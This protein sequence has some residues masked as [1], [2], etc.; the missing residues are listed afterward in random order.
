VVTDIPVCQSGFADKNIDSTETLGGAWMSAIRVIAL[1]PIFLIAGCSTGLHE[2]V[3]NGFK[4]GP[5]YCRPAAPVAEN[6]IDYQDSRVISEPPQHWAWWTVFNDPVLNTLIEDA[7]RQNLTLREA[8]FRIAE[9]RALLGFTVGNIFPQFQEAFGSYNRQQRSLELGAIGGGLPGGG[10]GGGGLG[11]GA[12][13]PR[14]F[15]IWTLGTQLAWELDF[16]G[17]FRRAIEAADAELDASVENYDDVLVILLADVAS[18]YVEVRTLEE[19]LRFARDNVKYQSG[20]LNLAKIRLEEGA[21]SKLDVTQA[22]TNVSQTE[23][24]I[25]VLETQLR[26]AHNRLCVL[27]GAPPE[28]LSRQLGAARIPVAPP[29]VAVGVPAELIRRRPDIRRAERE[30]AAQSARIGIAE[31]DLYP[32]FT[33]TG[34][35]F[36][37]ASQFAD[38]FKSSAVGGNVGPSFNW[39]ILNYGRIRNL[40]AAEEARFLREATQYQNA[41][42]N[43]NREAED[44]IVAFLRAQ[45]QTARLREGVAAAA[46]SR[47]LV[48]ELYRGGRADFGRVFVAEFFLAQQQDLLAQAEGSIAQALV[49]VY[50]ALGGGWE[51]R[52]NPAPIAVPP[53]GPPNAPAMPPGPAPMPPEP[54]PL[55]AAGAAPNADPPPLLPSN[56]R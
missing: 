20:S 39:N 40:V 48:M 30:V 53:S 41:V 42:L 27:L 24:A 4:V 47:D 13:F 8:G 29:E 44:A 14:N 54:V 23:A 6:W 49:A 11:G 51:I 25:P 7:H 33:I 34:S 17:R 3:H 26:Q 37:Q 2:Y 12:G 32:A 55:P 45:V 15:S 38:L 52:L 28:D 31:A 21:A 5:N 43:A 46:E 36:V 9:S 10:L 1:L 22:Q 16:W 35:I 19:R 50:R 56:P 18:T